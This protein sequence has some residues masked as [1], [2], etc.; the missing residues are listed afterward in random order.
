MR[1]GKHT[2]VLVDYAVCAP[3][4]CAPDTGVCASVAAC[5]HKVIKQ[6][7]GR[8]EPPALFQDLCLSCGDCEQ[9]C[10]LGAIV[11]RTTF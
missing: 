10:P 8:F 2:I 4:Q 3:G 5:T 6:I 11:K 1:S 9:A 7:D